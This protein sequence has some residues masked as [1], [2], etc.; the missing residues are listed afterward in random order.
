[1]T[2]T[3]PQWWVQRPCRHWTPA[4]NRRFRLVRLDG[5]TDYC[6]TYPSHVFDANSGKLVHQP[7]GTNGHELLRRAN[8]REIPGDLFMEIMS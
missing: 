1:M 7:Y 5:P 4:N 3:Y 8:D 2:D 6:G